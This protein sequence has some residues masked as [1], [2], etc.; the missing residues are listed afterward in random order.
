MNMSVFAESCNV[1]IGI[2]Y[3]YLT[4]SLNVTCGDLCCVAHINIQRLGAIALY[5]KNNA[6]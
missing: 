1:P 5:F 6:L 4:V 2:E 3:L